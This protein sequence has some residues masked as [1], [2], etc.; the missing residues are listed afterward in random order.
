LIA[1]DREGTG[2]V[3]QWLFAWAG[4]LAV[5]LAQLS[6]VSGGRRNRL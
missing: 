6:A 1:L 5:I 4:L 2:A 3:D